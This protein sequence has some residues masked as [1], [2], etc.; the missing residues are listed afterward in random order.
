[1]LALLATGA[2]LQLLRWLPEPVLTFV[3]FPMPYWLTPDL[4]NATVLRAL[5]LA[6]VS[7]LIAGVIPVMRTTSRSVQQ[8]LQRASTQRTGV[9]FGLAS[10]VMIV[11]DVAVA[12]AAVG[13]ATGVFTRVTATFA[14]E[15]T[16]G[17]RADRYLSVRLLMTGEPSADDAVSDRQ[18]YQTRFASTQAALVEQLRAEPGVRAVAV[19]TALPRMDHR[20]RHIHSFVPRQA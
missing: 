15:Q 7:A 12:V 1:V 2:G 17:I 5:G 11:A 9:R 20:I 16:D 19:G 14:N 10:S 3:G 4:S 6:G 13:F 8:N 18:A